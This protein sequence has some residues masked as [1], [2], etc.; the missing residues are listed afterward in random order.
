MKTEPQTRQEL[1]QEL[2]K[3]P[4]FEHAEPSLRQADEE[5]L[6]KWYNENKVNK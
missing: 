6:R 2:L 4:F 1:I 5:M 3:I